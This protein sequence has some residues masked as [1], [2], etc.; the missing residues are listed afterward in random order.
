MAEICIRY[1]LANLSATDLN[2]FTDYAALFWP[3]HFCKAEFHQQD[4]T[5]LLVIGLCEAKPEVFKDWAGFFFEWNQIPEQTTPLMVA[6]VHG[7]EA[8]VRR[9]LQNRGADIDIR[10]TLSSTPLSF[11]AQYGYEA[12]VQLLLETGQVD[13]N[14]Q[15]SRHETPLSVAAWLGH[16]AVVK[17]LL[18]TGKVDVNC[19]D[20]DNDT[21]LSFAARRGDEPVVKLL[22]DT[23]HLAA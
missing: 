12:V 3:V 22:L 15:D 18:K 5:V 7:L 17:L 13:L 10:D 16:E 9:L 14:S 23:D 19:K 4:E 11:A 20:I 2:G 8:V 21:P 6:S 1:L